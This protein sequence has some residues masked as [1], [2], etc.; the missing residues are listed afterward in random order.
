[1]TVDRAELRRRAAEE[2]GPL[3]VPINALELADLLDALER[4]RATADRLAF[5]L[6]AWDDVR[7]G[8]LTA[9]PMTREALAAYD[10]TVAQR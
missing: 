9:A 1:M 2:P 8:E 7:C 3:F 5:E 10:A 4:E 6:R